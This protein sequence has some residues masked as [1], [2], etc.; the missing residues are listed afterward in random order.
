MT[1]RSGHTL[2]IARSARPGEGRPRWRAWLFAAGFL[3]GAPACAQPLPPEWAR[4][5][6][7]RLETQTDGQNWL[8]LRYLAP[9]IA[10][11]GGTLAYDDVAQAIDSLCNKDGM[12]SVAALEGK[13]Q[14][15]DQ[16]VITVMDRVVEWGTASPE[17]TM[18]LGTYLPS[19]DGC[20]WQ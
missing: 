9:E 2:G 20:I 13:G 16:V 19:D 4:F 10:R 18:F 11:D 5:H 17:A 12:A 3:L 6:D 15:V 1:K 7:L 14:T 8:I